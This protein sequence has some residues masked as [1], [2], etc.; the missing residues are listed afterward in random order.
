MTIDSN[1]FSAPLVLL[2]FCAGLATETVFYA[3]FYIAG[4]LATLFIAYLEKNAWF[5]G[6]AFGLPAGFMTYLTFLHGF[7]DPFL[8]V[9]G[10]PVAGFM[11]IIGYGLPLDK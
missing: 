2:W 5:V 10:L 9:V 1:W 11:A 8:I 6:T 4:I 3:P 7:D